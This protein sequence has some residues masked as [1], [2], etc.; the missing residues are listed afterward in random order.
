MS[1]VFTSRTM[2]D[3]GKIGIEDPWAL[4]LNV[5]KHYDDFTVP[6]KSVPAIMR[7][8]PGTSFYASLKLVSVATS[9]EIDAQKKANGQPAREGTGEYVNIE[10]TDGMRSLKAMVFG[11]VKPWE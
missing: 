1:D 2:T 3:L 9:A 10:L 11:R 5:P 4:L 7:L 6:L 8:E